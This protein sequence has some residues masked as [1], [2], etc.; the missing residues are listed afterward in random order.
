MALHR[1]VGDAALQAGNS[2]AIVK[3]H[4]LNTHTQEEGGEFFRIIPCK[5]LAV[6]SKPKKE[7]P[8]HLKA[9]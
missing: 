7:Q 8:A 1:S 4:Y 6:L 9:V 5:R 3:R 2:E